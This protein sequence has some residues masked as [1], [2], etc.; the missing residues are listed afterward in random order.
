MLVI[1][2]EGA[3]GISGGAFPNIRLECQAGLLLSLCVWAV[4]FIIYLVFPHVRVS[5]DPST[6]HPL[7]RHPL[8]PAGL[9]KRT[10]PSTSF[11]LVKFVLLK[12]YIG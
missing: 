7:P 2:R 12:S 11:L 10:L 9:E 5:N 1:G 6:T 8:F 4:I 3:M